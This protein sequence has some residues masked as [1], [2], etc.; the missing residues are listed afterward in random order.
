MA[1]ELAELTSNEGGT[2][3]EQGRKWKGGI[4][5]NLMVGSTTGKMDRDSGTVVL[6]GEAVSACDALRVGARRG[7]TECRSGF[8]GAML[9]RLTWGPKVIKVVTAAS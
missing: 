6:S 3:D 9:H 8:R 5:R 4:T 2:E 7:E 1:L